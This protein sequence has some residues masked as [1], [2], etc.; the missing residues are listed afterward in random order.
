MGY[1]GDENLWLTWTAGSPWV[2]GLGMSAGQMVKSP[3]H[4]L[5]AVVGVLITLSPML[6]IFFGMM[7]AFAVLSRSGVQ[8]SRGLAGAIGEVLLGSAALFVVMPLGAMLAAYCITK[9]LNARKG[10]PPLPGLGR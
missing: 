5:G 10:P 6:Y 7:R 1:C 2:S 8:D 4:F 9:L 3:L